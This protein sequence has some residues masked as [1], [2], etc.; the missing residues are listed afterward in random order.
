[1][2]CLLYYWMRSYDLFWYTCSLFLFT[3]WYYQH[4]CILSSFNKRWSHRV[5]KINYWVLSLVSNVKSLKNNVNDWSKKQGKRFYPFI[6]LRRSTRAEFHTQIEIDTMSDPWVDT[7]RHYFSLHHTDMARANLDKKI[8]KRCEINCLYID[9]LVN[10]FAL[11]HSGISKH[12]KKK[13]LKKEKSLSKR[14][15]KCTVIANFSTRG[16]ETK[17]N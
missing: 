13:Y 12:A 3:F 8:A 9:I 10:H 11:H 1:M 2:S 15:N 6:I 14:R 5:L 16:V 7:T 4:S 17:L